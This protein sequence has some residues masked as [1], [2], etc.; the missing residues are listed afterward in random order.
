MNFYNK[1]LYSIKSKFTNHSK[2]TE[3]FTLNV[4]TYAPYGAYNQS[5]E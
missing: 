2:E 3:I 4:K 1:I 5:R